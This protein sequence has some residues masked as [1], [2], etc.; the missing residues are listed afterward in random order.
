MATATMAITITTTITITLPVLVA[1]VLQLQHLQ[2]PQQQQ[3]RRLPRGGNTSA[4]VTSMQR[5]RPRALT[6]LQSYAALSDAPVGTCAN[7][8]E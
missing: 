7:V 6:V 4:V 2:H 8:T 5:L 1:M 3:L